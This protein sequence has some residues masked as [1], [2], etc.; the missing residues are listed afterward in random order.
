MKSKGINVNTR[1][2]V[3]MAFWLAINNFRGVITGLF[4]KK[5]EFSTECSH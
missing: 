4:I 3:C 2:C 5:I 1:F